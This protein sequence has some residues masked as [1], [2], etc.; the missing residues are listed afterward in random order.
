VDDGEGTMLGAA[1]RWA[2]TTLRAPSHDRPEIDVGAVEERLERLRMMAQR[3]STNRRTLTEINA[4]VDKV[5][6]SL[7][8]M[9]RDLIEL[10]DDATT[11]LRA[12]QP[13]PVLE[14][15]RTS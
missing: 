7:D 4:S 8:G 1:L 15:Q 11:A 12:P 9:R 2:V 14:L 5:R 6:D 10:V 3:F 13:A